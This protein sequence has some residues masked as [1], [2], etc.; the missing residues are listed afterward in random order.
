MKRLREE[1]TKPRRDG[2]GTKGRTK[3]ETEGQKDGVKKRWREEGTEKKVWREGG[4]ERRR[5]GRKKGKRE[6]VT[7]ELGTK[8]RRGVSG[9]T[10]V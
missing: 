3:E 7:E 9:P 10:T 1:G 8:R 4:T 6:E 5:S 2:G